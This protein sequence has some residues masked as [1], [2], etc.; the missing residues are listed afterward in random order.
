M[1][2][3]QSITGLALST[4]LKQSHFLGPWIPGV[5]FE[6]SQFEREHTINVDGHKHFPY[7]RM[8]FKQKHLSE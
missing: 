5:R 6:T 2:E 3:I 8:I 4:V 7:G 1:I